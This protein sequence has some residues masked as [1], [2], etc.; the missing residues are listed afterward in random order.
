MHRPLS[1][2]A[3]A[4]L[5]RA[6]GERKHELRRRALNRMRHALLQHTFDVWTELLGE[7]ERRAQLIRPFPP[8]WPALSLRVA[9]ARSSLAQLTGRAQ[10]S[11][12]K[13]TATRP[14]PSTAP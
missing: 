8:A 9:A 4:D 12:K 10:L 3:W 2:M 11:S 14:R 13:S 5:A 6:E 7:A 1:Y